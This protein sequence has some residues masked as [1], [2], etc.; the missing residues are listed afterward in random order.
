MKKVET[1]SGYDFYKGKDEKGED[2]FNIVPKDAIAPAAGYY[3]SDH[4]SKMKKVPNLF[5]KINESKKLDTT[6][7]YKKDILEI[8]SLVDSLKKANKKIDLRNPIIN[9]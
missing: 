6:I 4:I 2:V 7:D 8:N 9:F 1:F 3:D 5:K